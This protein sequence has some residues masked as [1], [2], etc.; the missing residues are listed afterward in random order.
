MQITRTTRT[1]CSACW[2]AASSLCLLS[3]VRVQRIATGIS[4]VVFVSPGKRGLLTL[5]Q[6]QLR[7]DHTWLGVFIPRMEER[8]RFT[9]PQRA[10]VLCLEMI[11]N[12]LVCITAINVD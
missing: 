2:I 12:L 9:R 10:A 11:A 7:N 5:T 1:T 3:F 8:V 6:L 4:P